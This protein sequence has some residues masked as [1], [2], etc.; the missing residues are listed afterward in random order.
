MSP[1]LFLAMVRISVLVSHILFATLQPLFATGAG[2][3]HSTGDSNADMALS[4]V[5]PV[6]GPC[7]SVRGTLV[8][9]VS[10][11]I[12]EARATVEATAHQSSQS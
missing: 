8:S 12:V 11:A 7:K 1:H 9:R 5:H 4:S 10:G 2:T 3:Q 6:E